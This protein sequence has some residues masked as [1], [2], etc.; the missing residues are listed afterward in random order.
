MKKLTSILLFAFS[1]LFIGV[2]PIFTQC[3]DNFTTDEQVLTYRLEAKKTEDASSQKT[4][5]H[6]FATFDR[7]ERFKIALDSDI[8]SAFYKPN[9]YIVFSVLENVYGTWK[10]YDEDTKKKYDK[11]CVVI[12]KDT[13]VYGNVDYANSRYP[14]YIGGKAKLFVTVKTIK[15]EDGTE[16]DIHFVEPPNQ[17]PGIEPYKRVIKPCKHYKKRDCIA[18]R[19]SKPT[20]PPT[21]VGAGTGTGLLVVK[22]DKTTATIAGL[23]FIESLSKVTGIENLINPPN[24]E[25]KAKMIFDVEIEGIKGNDGTTTKGVW[26]VVKKPE[27]P[28]KTDEKPQPK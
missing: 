18:G 11:R 23:T 15:L 13:K 2:M 21:V 12:P 25:L 9:D 27:E 14:F 28:K 20:L 19:R 1:Y 5:T 3:T 16:I 7:Q 22:D 26:V 17:I 24:A 6:I 4:F 8:T 10:F